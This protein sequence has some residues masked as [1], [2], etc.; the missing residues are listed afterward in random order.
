VQTDHPVKPIPSEEWQY[1]EHLLEL[2]RRHLGM[3]VAYLSEFTAQEQVVRVASG[4]TSAMNV[5]VGEGSSLEGS[6]CARVLA[7]ELPQV[8]PDARR[9][10]ITRELPIT[11]EMKIGSY[12]GVPWQDPHGN[13]AGMLCCVSKGVTPG[14]DNQGARFLEVV[15]D[16]ISNHMSNPAVVERT[17]AQL[18]AE[19]IRSMVKCGELRMVFQPVVRLE[20][21][22]VLGF[23]SLARFDDPMFPTPAHAFAAAT[24]AGVG[25][26]LELLAA[27]QAL[28]QLDQVPDGAWMSINLSAE[29]IASPLAQELLLSYAHRDIAVEI[30][31]HTQVSDYAALVTCSERL[32]AAGVKLLVDDAGAGFASFSHI[33]RLRPDVIKLDIELTRGVDTDP[34]RQALAGAL[35]DF[36]RSLDAPLIAEGIETEAE[37]ETLL[38]LGVRLGQGFLMAR[39]GSMSQLHAGADLA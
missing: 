30:T 37:R 24:R 20:D 35:V 16:L 6:Y 18:E 29:A 2:A 25:V 14:L 34:V 8:I 10:L 27:R 12:V 5:T 7:G 26:E 17:E 38:G 3:Q 11:G 28:E 36:A 19:N 4:D 21:G 23:E 9:H 31:E 39:P 13:T 1:L 22:G 15:A 33:L 32:R